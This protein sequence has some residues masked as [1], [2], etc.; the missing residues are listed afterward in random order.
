M[1]HTLSNTFWDNA[2][3]C[4]STVMVNAFANIA[5]SKMENSL[6]AL[7]DFIWRTFNALNAASYANVRAAQLVALH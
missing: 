1:G 7:Q 3:N 6:Y 5:W 2:P 4:N